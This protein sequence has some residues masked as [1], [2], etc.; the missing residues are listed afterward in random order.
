MSIPSRWES[1]IE[2]QIRQAQER[3]E[4]DD[5]PGA[6][7]PI[8][9][10][11][12]PDDELWWVKDYVRREGVPTDTLL[13]ASL[14][15]ARRVEHL[16]E[17]L[18]RLADEAAVRETVTALNAEIV[19]WLRAPW[20]P[21]VA[22]R[23]VD[24]EAAAADWLAR[25]RTGAGTPAGTAAEPAT[26][27]GTA[28]GATTRAAPAAEPATGATTPTSPPRSSSRSPRGARRWNPFARH[29]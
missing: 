1:L 12:R 2:A 23:Q 26:P 13:P 22:L 15:L 8:P 25:R 24:V 18:D 4:F 16:P 3:G 6:G 20:G 11:D 28:A 9:H 21:P 29:P 10:T 7:K 27:A 14:R 5:L 17:E 19:A